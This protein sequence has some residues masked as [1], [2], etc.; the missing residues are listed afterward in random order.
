[1]SPGFLTPPQNHVHLFLPAAILEV[2]WFRQD[3]FAAEAF[4][5]MSG[6]FP[7]RHDWG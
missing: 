4:P 6:I 3:P 1:M 7:S 2:L 5:K